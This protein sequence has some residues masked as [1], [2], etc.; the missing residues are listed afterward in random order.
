MYTLKSDPKGNSFVF[1]RV[2]LWKH[3]DSRENKTNWFPKGPD[4]KRFVTF[5]DF[6]FNILQQQQEYAYA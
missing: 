3:Q 4:I 1:P 2:H 5:L 6:Y